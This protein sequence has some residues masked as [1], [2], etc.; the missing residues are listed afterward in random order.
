[1]LADL[2]GGRALDRFAHESILRRPRQKA[3]EPDG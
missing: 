3:R 2:L 1:V